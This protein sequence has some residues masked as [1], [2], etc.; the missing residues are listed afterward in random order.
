M[1]KEWF[2]LGCYA[3]ENEKGDSLILVHRKK[4]DILLNG[5]PLVEKDNKKSAFDFVREY[6]KCND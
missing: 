4:W 3:W 6:M 2:A 1:W 5:E